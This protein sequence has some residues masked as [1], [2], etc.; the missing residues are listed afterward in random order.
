MSYY[1]TQVFK[2]YRPKLLN[3]AG[4]IK[5][6]REEFARNHLLIVG[7]S[8]GVRENADLAYTLCKILGVKQLAIERS[9]S[10]FQPFVQSAITGEPNFLLPQVLP[11]LQASVLSLEMLKTIAVLAQERFVKTIEYVDL[12]SSTD[13][14]LNDL[15]EKDYMRVREQ[16]IAKNITALDMSVPTL[17]ILGNYHTYQD[18]DDI[19][20][21][22]AL[23]MVREKQSAI[24][25]QYHYIS[26]SQYNA[27][28]LLHFPDISAGQ[29]AAGYRL[30]ES[31]KGD[32]TIEVP[33]AHTILV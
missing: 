12:D 6:L 3:I 18:V 23:S 27:G 14:T 20:G 11:S 16:Q 25:L 7:E 10:K 17:V 19:I 29:S 5:G 31:S 15:N 32:F 33:K 26:G 13:S 30:T 24:Y 22:S 28:R 1:Y 9:A 4:S 21:E 8:H 2:R